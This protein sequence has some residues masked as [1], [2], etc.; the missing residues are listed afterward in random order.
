MNLYFRLI[1]ILLKISSCKIIKADETSIIKY[2]AWP[3]D[4]DI[5]FHM[6]GSRYTALMD[7]SRVYFIGQINIFSKLIKRKWFPVVK[8]QEITFYKPIKPLQ[9]FEVQTKLL[10]WEDKYCYVRQRIVSND[11]VCAE[12]IIKGVFVGNRKTIPLQE[13]MELAGRDVQ[14]PAITEMIRRFDALQ[15][16]KAAA[17]S[18][19]NNKITASNA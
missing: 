6:T 9:E 14:S 17:I 2:R 10:A 1:R 13:V 3:F 7:L 5:N 12:A 16:N 11:T 4:C 8:A 19:L 18:K 15:E